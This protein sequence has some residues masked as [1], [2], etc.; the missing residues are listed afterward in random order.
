MDNA[1]C[2]L[3]QFFIILISGS[4]LVTSWPWDVFAQSDV[5]PR[6]VDL[7]R[8][9]DPNPRPP[10]PDDPNETDIAKRGR[11]RWALSRARVG[12]GFP[13]PELFKEAK[14]AIPENEQRDLIRLTS[15]LLDNGLHP[16]A[17]QSIQWLALWADYGNPDA[18]GRVGLTM[19]AICAEWSIGK[20]TVRVD[21]S[22]DP[23]PSNR[24]HLRLRFPKRPSFVF[25]PRPDQSTFG[26]NLDDYW[27]WEYFSKTE[28]R[29]VLVEFFNLP[30]QSDDDFDVRGHIDHI[31][32]VMVYTGQIGPPRWLAYGPIDR[33]HLT[34]W[35]GPQRILITDSDPQY[36]CL[37]FKLPDKKVEAANP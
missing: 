11:F 25:R 33:P 35:D 36:I 37:S 16:L 6:D 5:L 9:T 19:T 32:G 26:D 34:E 21:R 18:A 3:R 14:D 28:L 4:V 22:R 2:Q 8:A 31:D 1:T 27:R 17:S 12:G 23:L 20:V 24:I 30:Y 13:S 7:H 15:G 10:P 29:K